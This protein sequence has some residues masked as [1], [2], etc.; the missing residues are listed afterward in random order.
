MISLLL[1]DGYARL[2]MVCATNGVGREQFKMV[3][4]TNGVGR[5]PLHLAAQGGSKAA[6]QMLL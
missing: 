6:M 3:R 1:Q 4:A 5:T 2:K